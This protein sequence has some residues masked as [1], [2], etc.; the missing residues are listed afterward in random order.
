LHQE[1]GDIALEG[2]Y[3]QGFRGPIV[4][5]RHPDSL[6]DIGGVS[7]QGR[8]T[9]PADNSLQDTLMHTDTRLLETAF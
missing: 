8:V 4:I 9:G 3:F 6:M 5:Q 2:L 7:G 1:G